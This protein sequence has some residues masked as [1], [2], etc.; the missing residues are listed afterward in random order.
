LRQQLGAERQAARQAA[1]AAA[2][3]AAWRGWACRERQ[4]CWV[5]HRLVIWRQQWRDAQRQV[6]EHQQRCSAVHIQVKGGCTW[7]AL[8]FD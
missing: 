6:Q 4:Q 7:R 8:L 3:Q 1:A 5:Q 2:V